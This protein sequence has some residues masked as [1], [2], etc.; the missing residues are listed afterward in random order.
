[1][2]K[3]STKNKKQQQTNK[4]KQN[5]AKKSGLLN[6]IIAGKHKGQMMQKKGEELKQKDEKEP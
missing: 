6:E 4:Q 1:M 5:K 2:N 3:R